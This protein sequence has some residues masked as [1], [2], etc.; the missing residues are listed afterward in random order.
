MNCVQVEFAS[1][2]SVTYYGTFKASVELCKGSSSSQLAAWCAA[3]SHTPTH[4]LKHPARLPCAQIVN[5]SRAGEL[6]LLYQCGTPNPQTANTEL[7]LPPGT[8]VF[9]VPLVSVA[10]TDSNAAGFL[11]SFQ[12]HAWMLCWPL[13]RRCAA[14][15]NASVRHYK[16]TT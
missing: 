8:K 10:V 11:V 6:Y 3:S 9:E 2:F 14:P 4:T 12:S 16:R 5:N 7:D 13:A 15:D 1:D